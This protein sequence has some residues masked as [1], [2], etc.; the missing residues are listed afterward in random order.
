[1]KHVLKRSRTKDSTFSSAK[2]ISKFGAGA[3]QA[4]E[5]ADQGPCKSCK[6][7]ILEGVKQVR[8]CLS[9]TRGDLCR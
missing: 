3:N 4:S 7:M 8:E 6:K 9:A 2:R 1:M 5:L